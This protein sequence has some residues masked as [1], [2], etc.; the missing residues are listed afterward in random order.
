V[1][2]HL[3][4]VSIRIARS[5]SEQR[6]QL[7]A[8]QGAKVGRRLDRSE[9]AALGVRQSLR[10][11]TG[12]AT[13]GHRAL[14]AASGRAHQV[15][16]EL[17]KQVGLRAEGRE[18]RDA[19]AG[20]LRGARARRGDA[21]DRGIGRLSAQR[22]GAATLPVTAGSPSTSRRSSTIWNERPT[23]GRS[24]RARFAARAPARQARAQAISTGA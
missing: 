18:R 22:V 12:A 7:A 15:A 4:T 1:A 14:R 3:P 9:Q 23:L 17:A 21:R 5:S 10:Q 16:C 19:L 11:S 8:L 6:S 13:G 2:A 20:E 24:G